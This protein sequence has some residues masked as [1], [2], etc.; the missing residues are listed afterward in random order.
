MKIIFNLLGVGLGNN[1][2]SRTLVRLADELAALGCSVNIAAT[3]YRNYTLT[4]LRVPICSK[5]EPCDALIATGYRSV[6]STLQY[7]KAERKYYYIRGLEIWQAKELALR[8]SFTSGLQCITNAQWIQ[9]YIQQLG[10][11]CAWVPQGIDFHVW[12]DQH[13]K[14]KVD[15][16]GVYHTKHQSKR[17][18][19]VLET[20][21]LANC[22]VSL[23]GKD[24]LA[25]RDDE[26][27]TCYN[28][29]LVW[30][31][32]SE[33]EGL[34]NCTMEAALSGCALVLSDHPRNGAREYAIDRETCLVYPSRDLSIAAECVSRLIGDNRLREKL[35]QNARNAIRQIV[36]TKAEAAHQFLLSIQK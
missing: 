27:V 22:S 26:L 13:R 10:V 5:L 14:R 24:V 28:R 7:N 1:G 11:A 35:I 33:N 15:L 31:S 16:G 2:G 23:L 20:A 34:Q 32:P 3:E 4:P 30:M 25:Q 36:G 12:V 18:D 21:R 19:A 8:R 9:Q 17:H 29:F 6:G